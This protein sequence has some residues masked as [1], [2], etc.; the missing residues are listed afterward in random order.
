MSHFENHAY[1]GTRHTSREAAVDVLPKTGTQRRM[2]Y[3]HIVTRG[4]YGATIDECATSLDMPVQSVT[5]RRRELEDQGLLVDS[6][7]V[8]KGTYSQ[9]GIV[10]VA[11][12]EGDAKP[13]VQPQTKDSQIA[14]LKAQLAAANEKLVAHGILL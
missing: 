9:N 1:T 12:D 2:V 14:S 8:R 3:D 7:V 10:W 4:A 11:A 13:Y 6:G 5:P